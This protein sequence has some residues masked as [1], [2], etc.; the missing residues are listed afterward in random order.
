MSD[1]ALDIQAVHKSFRRTQV[2]RGMT[3]QVERGQTFAFLGRNGAG[4]TTT[5]AGTLSASRIGPQRWEL[6]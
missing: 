5:M 1:L 6:W 3:L 2:L 4:K